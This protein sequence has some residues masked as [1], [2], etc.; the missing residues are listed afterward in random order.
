MKAYVVSSVIAASFV[1]TGSELLGVIEADELAQE[2]SGELT[3]LSLA[4]S[5]PDLLSSSSSSRLSSLLME[6]LTSL[7]PRLLLMTLLPALPSRL[8]LP[9]DDVDEAAEFVEVVTASE[10]DNVVDD[11]IFRCRYSFMESFRF[12]VI[13]AAGSGVVRAGFNRGSE[14]AVFVKIF[15]Y[16]LPVPPNVD[17]FSVTFGVDESR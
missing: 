7:L 15:G 8:L 3:P 4:F 9:L 10:E 17:R 1:P 5:S 16:V 2:S 11:C 13:G 6:L 14:L 12:G